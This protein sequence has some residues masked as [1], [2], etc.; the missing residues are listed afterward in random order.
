MHYTNPEGGTSLLASLRSLN[1]NRRLH[2]SEALRI[3]ELQAGRLLE[4]RDALDVPVPTTVV[5]GLPRVTVEH[6]TDLPDDAASGSSH[7]N[8]QRRSW[9][10]CLN[11]TEPRTRRRF[12]LFHEYKHILDHGSPGIAARRRLSGGKP[13]EEIVAD[14]FAG[15][16]LMPRRLLKTAYFDGIQRPGDLAELF[17]VSEAAM[18]VRL[19]Q[20]GLSDTTAST[21]RFRYQPRAS[22]SSHNYW[23]NSNHVRQLL[24]VA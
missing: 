15:C 23:R 3:A 11:P 20:L 12:T 21:H 18:N 7:W 13:V 19:S 14:Y 17:D 6:D 9:I 24:E 2:L 5:T 8:W 16:V 1:P 10:I 22:R 4:L